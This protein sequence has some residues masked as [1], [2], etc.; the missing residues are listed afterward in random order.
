MGRGMIRAEVLDAL[1]EAGASA[2]MIVAAVK[3]AASAEEAKRDERRAK[4]A[5]RQR[6]LRGTRAAAKESPAKPVTLRDGTDVPPND[7]DLT[8]LSPRSSEEDLAPLAERLAARGT[9]GRR[10]RVPWPAG[11]SIRGGARR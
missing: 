3:A 6:R 11:R 2:E 10:R 9:R 4:D 8:P 7:K 1:L 5:A